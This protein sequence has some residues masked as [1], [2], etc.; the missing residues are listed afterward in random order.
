MKLVLGNKSYENINLNNLIDYFPNNLRCNLG[1][2]Y[3]KNGS[4]KDDLSLCSHLYKYL[5]EET[6]SIDELWETYKNDG[7]DWDHFLFCVSSFEPSDYTRIIYDD[8]MCD[9]ILCNHFLSSLGCPF[10]LSKRPRTGLASILKLLSEDLRLFIFGFSICDETRKTHYVKDFIFEKED[11]GIS[12]HSKND[13]LTILRWLHANGK[14]DATL[15]MLEDESIP[16]LKKHDLEPTE[17]SIKIIESVYGSLRI[18]E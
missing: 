12:F 13:E 5:I 4:I 7:Y 2:P 17:E 18:E 3:G 8:A 10:K 16:T 9:T 6:H 14:V 1:I 11:K 15:C